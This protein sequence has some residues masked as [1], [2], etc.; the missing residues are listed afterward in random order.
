MFDP[1]PYEVLAVPPNAGKAEVLKAFAKALQQRKYPPDILAKA[2]K[3]L[4][5][6]LDR[7]IAHY[8]WGS[9]QQ[10]ATNSEIN[11]AVLELLQAEIDRLEKE[12]Q[13]TETVNQLTAEMIQSETMLANQILSQNISTF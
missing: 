2:R 3:S 4:V 7:V 11:P 6:P 10:A 8:L 5:D 12:I 13:V 9:W 1:H